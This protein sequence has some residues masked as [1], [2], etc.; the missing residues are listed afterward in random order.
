MTRRRILLKG[1]KEG[2][3]GGLRVKYSYA[4][5]YFPYLPSYYYTALLLLRIDAASL[6]I[7]FS[8]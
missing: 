1:E 6:L 7:Y 4:W 2:V 3:D 8:S 5:S